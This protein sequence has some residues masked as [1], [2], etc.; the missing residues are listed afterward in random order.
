[1]LGRPF[2]TLSCLNSTIS[3]S[4]VLT[5]LLSTVQSGSVLIFYNIDALP[6]DIW[7]LLTKW[8]Q[9]IYEGM[10]S[11]GLVEPDRTPSIQQTTTTSYKTANSSTSLSTS[12]SEHK[13]FVF[14]IMNYNY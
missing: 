12:Y 8:L 1:M 14:S 7:L 2:F 5:N 3:S 9:E 4:L 10:K 13:R 11:S 6:I